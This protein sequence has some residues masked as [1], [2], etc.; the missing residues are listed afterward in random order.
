M[1][2]R[3]KIRRNSG[4]MK[5]KYHERLPFVERLNNDFLDENIYWDNWKDHRDGLRSNFY[6]QKFNRMMKR[7]RQFI[8]K[9][10]FKKR[11]LA[12]YL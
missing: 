2:K 6:K 3:K 8:Q 5:P 7:T 9:K 1:A 11:R 10:F 12:K 4:R